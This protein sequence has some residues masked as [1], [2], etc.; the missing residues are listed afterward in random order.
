MKAQKRSYRMR[1]RRDQLEDTRTRIVDAVVS[2]H[3]ECG[4]RHTTVSEIARRAG[5]ERLTVYRHLPD[6][7]AQFQACSHRFLEKNPPPDPA[8]WTGL[9]DPEQRLLTALGALY[10][11]FGR[12][13]RM[14]ANI[15]RDAPDYPVLRE[16]L[17]GFEAYLGGIADDLARPARGGRAS[18]R[19]TAVLRHAVR[20]ETWR[21]F[22]ADGV[23]DATKAGLIRSWLQSL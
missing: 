2:L 4:P 8:T 23:D 21:S 1:A 13:R 5:V 15:H 12:T 9:P 18:R 20:F 7:A 10:T 3:E 6:E 22:E 19:R 11:Y 14:L 17:A 16:I